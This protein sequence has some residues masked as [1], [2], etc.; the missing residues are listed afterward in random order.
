MPTYDYRCKACDHTFSVVQSF[1]EASLEDCPKCPGQ[2]RKLFNSV[3]VVFKGSGFYRTDNR[4][5]SSSVPAKDSGS[6]DSNKAGS[7][8]TS[9]SGKSEGGSSTSKSSSSSSGSS[10]NSSSKSSTA[11]KSASA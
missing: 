6:G 9:G 7:G 5:G 8:S 11:A 10:S 2:V 1:S 3:G 4:S